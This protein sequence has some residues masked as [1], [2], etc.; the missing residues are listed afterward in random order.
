MRCGGRQLFSIFLFF[1]VWCCVGR[2]FGFGLYLGFRRGTWEV[3]CVLRDL[4]VEILGGLRNGLK[5]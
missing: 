5:V 3:L 1:G 2:C 4:R